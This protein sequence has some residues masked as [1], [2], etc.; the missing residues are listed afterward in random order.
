MDIDEREKHDHSPDA[1]D[2]AATFPPKVA[3]DKDAAKGT[4][5]VRRSATDPEAQSTQGSENIVDKPCLSG[6]R[7]YLMIAALLSADVLVG[8]DGTIVATS[9]ATIANDFHALGDVGWY[10]SAYLLCTVAF[11]PSFGRAY[12]FFPQRWVFITA[13]SLFE[14]GC[15]VAAVAPSSLVLIIGRA[16]QGM[17][18]AGIFAGVLAISA[19][20]LS[21]PM[22]SLVTAGMNLCYGLGC[23]LGPV[24]G[25]A[26]TSSLSWRY[27]FVILIPCSALTIVSALFF[28][29]PTLLPQ[30]LPVRQRLAR[31]DWAGA[32]VLLDALCCLL[33]ALQTA[34][35]SSKW[36]SPRII[37]LLSGFVT[38]TGLF[39]VLQA[40]LDEQASISLRLLKNRSLACAAIVNLASGATYYTLLYWIPLYFQTT[41]GASPVRAGVCFLPVIIANSLCGM[42]AGWS[43]SRYG[44]YWPAM[45]V[46]AGSTA[47]GAGLHAS[48]GRHTATALWIVS[49]CFAGAGMGKSCLPFGAWYMMQFVATQVLVSDPDDKAR[50]ASLVCFTQLWGGTVFISVSN[51]IYMN[52]FKQGITRI[53]GIDVQAVIESGV[54]RFREVV[55]PD[56][57]DSVVDVAVRGL[58]N[59]FLAS[60]VL[61]AVG[62]VGV[63]GIDWVRVRRS[64]PAAINEEAK[65][66]KTILDGALHI[67]TSS[68]EMR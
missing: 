45:L 16:L 44:I 7:L 57:L 39:V 59:V 4:S 23:V 46:G 54:D 17:G 20:V 56:L 9:T 64:G 36:S 65:N 29:Y 52:T 21:I 43:V 3:S 32:V 61:G 13:L 30:D 27:Y 35:I 11:Q 48:L 37:G 41:Q 2:L 38:L 22:L 18:Y 6:A 12:R 49:G 68:E 50:A 51:S 63:F 42:L 62:F 34:G 67:E 40:Y 26:I 5:Y 8:L 15:I 31:I 60:A 10:G 47:L 55:A 53:P 25:G 66:G 14:L 28:C 1:V 19:N 33:I 58:F 24:V